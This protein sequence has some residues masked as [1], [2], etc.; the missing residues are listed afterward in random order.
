VSRFLPEFMRSALGIS[1]GAANVIGLH[2][3]G[4]AWL[5]HSATGVAHWRM[6][7]WQGAAPGQALDK[8]C[9]QLGSTQLS[10][11]QLV[12]APSMLRHWLQTPPA[13]IASMRELRD[14][15]SARCSQ[16]FGAAWPTSSD[17]TGWSVSAHWHASQ[18]FVC[19]AL[20]AAWTQALETQA[21]AFAF[22][23]QHDVVSLV[24]QHYHAAIPR[25]GW[26]A[27]VIAQSLYVMQLQARSV[28][29]LRVVR[30]PFQADTAHVLHTA[31]EEWTRE[32]L[33]SDSHA[34]T[35][36]CLYLHP[37]ATPSVMPAGLQLLPTQMSTRSP[38][39]PAAT[40]SLDNASTVSIS[41]ELLQEAVLTAWCAQQFVSG[42]AR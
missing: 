24:L 28:L 27:L 11:C 38:A 33:R 9:A 20:P 34:T 29:S 32:M 37:D 21:P 17:A 42:G 3:E 30:L 1:G 13:Q 35:L 15:A 6:L 4:A 12:F 41:S 10:G 39:P 8:L 18:P 7:A 22:S 23:A 14:V 5:E 16:L 26:L 40:T 36:S 19:S 25:T 31:K 2:A